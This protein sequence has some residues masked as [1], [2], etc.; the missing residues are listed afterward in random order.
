[1]PAGEPK[2]FKLGPGSLIIGDTGTPME[3]SCQITA[4]T[5][6]FETD[7]ED[8][9]PTLCG[10][11]LAGDEDETA[12]LT[13][14]II[15]DLSDDGIIE[16]TWANAGTVQPV[17]F[18]PNETMAKQIT[19]SVKIRSLNVGGDVKT[20]PTSDF[21][22]PFIGRPDLGAIAPPPAPLAARAKSN[23]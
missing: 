19:G 12:T 11:T 17:V 4:C 22:W 20:S 16:Y 8:D 5:V 13:G 1:M 23:A 10:G 18:I 14:T 9:V 3:I 21:E 6:E 15:Q 7:S 2:S